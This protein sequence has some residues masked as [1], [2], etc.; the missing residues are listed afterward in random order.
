VIPPPCEQS[1]PTAPA[2]PTAPPTAAAANT[3]AKETPQERLKRLMAAQI[4]SAFQK[5]SVAAAQRK[6]QVPWF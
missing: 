3:N 6:L 5:D 4:N 1:T 2:A